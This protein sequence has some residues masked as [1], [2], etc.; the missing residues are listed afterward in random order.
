VHDNAPTRDLAL[1]GESA[2]RPP[3]GEGQS[4]A[5]N[6]SPE[7]DP[8][9][10]TVGRYA[11]VGEI[12]RGGMGVVYR[13]TDPALGREVAVKLMRVAY[14]ESSAAVRR[15][16]DE[17][18]IT[19]QLQHPGIPPVFEVG[20]LPDGS[21]FLAMKLIKG[22]TLEAIL[23]DRGEPAKGVP[24]PLA[25]FEQICQAV[26]YA[27]A[28]DVI[29]RDLKP[30]NVMVGAFGEVQ[31]MDWGLAKVLTSATATRVGVA[32]PDATRGTEIQ[33]LRGEDAATQ[34]GSLL[35][36]PAFMPPEQAIGAV[37]QLDA[38]SDVFGLGAV[39]CVILT[40]KPPYLGAD[41]EST[42][43][44]AARAKLGDA[45]D[46]LSA[47]G[48]EPGWVALCRRCLAAEK[49]DRPAA[50][51]VVSAAVAAL[52]ADA[53]ERARQAELDRVRADAA[54]AAER[55]RR[56][57]ILAAAGAVAAVLAAGAGV[58][59]WQAIRATDAESATKTQL[60]KT[61]FAEAAS[62]VEA[63]NARAAEGKAQVEADNARA[64]EGKAREQEGKEKTARE[65]A[66]AVSNFMQEVF[67]QGSWVGQVSQAGKSKQNLTVKEAMDYAA[68]NIEKRFKDKPEIEA[69]VRATLGKT[70][71]ELE[72]YPEAL[73]QL[74]RALAIRRRVL[75]DLHPDTLTSIGELGFLHRIRG[76]LAAAEP[77]YQEALAGSRKVY[78]NDHEYTLARVHNLGLLLANR[79][80][81]GKSEALL[82]EGLA[83]RRKTLGD[84]DPATL[85][86]IFNLGEL[87]RRLGRNADAERMYKESLA[88]QRKALVEGHP[89]TL[90]NITA[91]AMVYQTQSR[92]AS[93]E[94]L[95]K[96][97]LAGY[98][99]TLGNSHNYTL[100]SASNLGHFYKSWG[101]YAEAET[102]LREVMVG[103]RTAFGETH[104]QTLKAV[105][106]VNALAI[107]CEAQE[108][109]ELAASLVSDVLAARR[110]ALGDANPQTLLSIN[111][112][113]VL[114]FDMG[115]FREA[116][117]LFRE[118][119]KSH[120]KQ[121]SDALATH[122]T[123]A[124]LG[125]SLLRSGAQ[126]E[127][128]PYLSTAYVGLKEREQTLTPRERVRLRQVTQGLVELYE[129]TGKPAEAEAWRAKV[130]ALPAEIA[131]TPR[132]ANP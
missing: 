128:E 124:Y 45:F 62:Q 40:G 107:E 60:E 111:Q 73:T 48:A 86:S 67:A 41:A 28:H 32:D 97:A 47:C 119:L 93:A 122:L 108:R 114:Y 35:G 43:Q 82:L 27:H 101:R 58:S 125:L 11:I 104:P 77:L 33:S 16:L 6:A 63:G 18:R 57:V 94:P 127:A 105:E 54:A 7:A 71:R 102:F 116:T 23:A 10:E 12:A 92:F 118:L 81:Y 51:G 76:R 95:F 46:R 109:F 110:K 4:T 17:A 70:Y 120:E 79:M 3:D 88:G 56:R 65:T 29:H 83:S 5:P 74:E 49:A 130:K 78:G 52:R 2:T 55:K 112:L 53:E 31:V 37:D 14:R 106:D 44:L 15:F 84:T 59:V 96:E 87:Y 66:E 121:T 42:R 20:A 132:P 25:V 50:G 89:Y 113:A 69:A 1:H 68:S 21:P 24:Y 123:R 91:L 13:A 100:I 38:R 129:M 22:H 85:N 8:V 30:A 131:P 26:G 99:K 34:A 36:T 75:G 115:R 80:E 61:R 117:S 64:A 9:P 103:R 19:G 126:G 90:N 72:A 98:R 39:L